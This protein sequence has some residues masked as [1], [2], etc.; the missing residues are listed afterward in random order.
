MDR[1]DLQIEVP[2]LSYEEIKQGE[3][4][5]TSDTARERVVKIREKQWQRF[6]SSRTNAEMTSRETK[7][8]CVLDK[9]GESLLKKVFDQNFFSARAYDRIL[10]VARTIADM[11]D[12]GEIRVEHLAESLQYRALDREIRSGS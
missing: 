1:F 3:N 5:E 10:R 4:V 6:K 12:S 8:I 9:E 11:A 7:E 2:R